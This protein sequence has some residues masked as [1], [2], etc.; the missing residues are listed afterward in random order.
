[1]S[2]DFRTV[3]RS[4]LQ[5]APAPGAKRPPKSQASRRQLVGQTHSFH[6]LPFQLPLPQETSRDVA[7]RRARPQSAQPFG[8]ITSQAA[9]SRRLSAGS[10]AASLPPRPSTA[11]AGRS[12]SSNRSG[13]AKPRRRPRSGRARVGQAAQRRPWVTDGT[14]PQIFQKLEQLEAATAR[15]DPQ[16]RL[17]ACGQLLDAVIQADSKFGAVLQRVKQEY[18]DHAKGVNGVP[19]ARLPID[20]AKAQVADGRL[21]DLNENYAHL[22]DEYRSAQAQMEDQAMESKI[23]AEQYEIVLRQKE[24]LTTQHDED[25][26][27]LAEQAATIARLEEAAAMSSAAAAQ[28]RSLEMA[29]MQGSSAEHVTKLELMVQELALEL[30]QARNTEALAL[31]ELVSLRELLG[32]GPALDAIAPPGEE[33]EGPSEGGSV[34]TLGSLGSGSELTA[35]ARSREP[36]PRPEEVPELDVSLASLG[37]AELEGLTADAQNLAAEREETAAADAAAAAAAA[38]QA[39]AALQPATGDE[40]GAV[41]SGEADNAVTAEAT[42]DGQ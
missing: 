3:Q 24:R 37:S 17:K 38:A 41:E 20:D 29:A 33:E 21:D 11:P 40:D 23:L 26:R 34:S 31:T 14:P 35:L 8:S 15:Q 12:S 6:E 19:G 4:P 13:S 28:R 36:V 5:H 2:V 42:S 22:G 10:S 16:E 30:D 7:R 9:S 1:M 27:Q 32:A 25:Q 18:E 39:E